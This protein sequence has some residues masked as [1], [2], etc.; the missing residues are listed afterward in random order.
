MTV[1]RIVH[2]FAGTLVLL[3]V[4]LAWAFSPWFLG[5]AVFVGVNLL[6]SAFTRVCPLAIILRWA[7]VPDPVPQEARPF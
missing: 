7:G 2:A 5:V 6:Q 1:G 3:S 4:L